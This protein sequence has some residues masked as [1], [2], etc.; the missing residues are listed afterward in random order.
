M[1]YD[2]RLTFYMEFQNITSYNFWIFFDPIKKN[3]TFRGAERTQSSLK[4]SLDT[5]LDIQSLAYI[6]KSVLRFQTIDEAVFGALHAGHALQHHATNACLGH[7]L[8]SFAISDLE[9]ESAGDFNQ[10]PA[11]THRPKQL[12]Q[13]QHTVKQMNFTRTCLTAP[14][15]VSLTNYPALLSLER[16]KWKWFRLKPSEIGIADDVSRH[17]AGVLASVFNQQ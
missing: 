11:T 17:L 8:Q 3:R 12:W 4:T 6:I 9:L 7:L 2:R 10:I 14:S 13:L 15:V 16:K 5:H 1:R